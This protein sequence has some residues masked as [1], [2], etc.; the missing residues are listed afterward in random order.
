MRQEEPVD[1]EFA[2]GC[3]ASSSKGT[4]AVEKMPWW[5]KLWNCIK[6]FFV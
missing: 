2:Q 5:K 6:C 1:M 4:K 3:G